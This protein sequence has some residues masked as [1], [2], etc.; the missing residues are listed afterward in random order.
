MSAGHSIPWYFHETGQEIKDIKC[1]ELTYLIT[2]SS[3]KSFFLKFRNGKLFS[4]AS[5]FGEEKMGE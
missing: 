3:I 4:I 1:I 2:K 5:I